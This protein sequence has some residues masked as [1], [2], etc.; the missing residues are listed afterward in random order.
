MSYFNKKTGKVLPTKEQDIDNEIT[1][2]RYPVFGYTGE[3]IGYV[4]NGLVYRKDGGIP[5]EA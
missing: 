1:L 5:V 4:D 2:L 3:Y